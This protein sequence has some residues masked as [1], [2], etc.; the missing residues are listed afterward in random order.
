MALFAGS[1]FAVVVPLVGD[2][3][4]ARLAWL[5]PL[6]AVLGLLVADFVGGCVHWLADTYF[7]PSTPLLGPML[8]EPFRDHHRDPEGITRHGFCELLGNN[9]LGTLPLAFG[10]L[11]WGPPGP[12]VGAQLLQATIVALG[13]ALF[14]TN[15]FHRFAHE[16]HPPL[17]G[18]WLQRAGLALSAEAHARHHCGE[19]DR[20]YCV[21]SGWLNPLLDRV[22]FFGRAE[23]LLR[24]LGVRRGGVRVMGSARAAPR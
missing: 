21:T 23:A 8:I 12:G 22:R 18:A 2:A 1:W 17:L 5:L 4:G 19:H 15:A 14:S 24:C 10:L 13:L 7:E 3:P 6:A 20:S 11:L 16:K 9:A